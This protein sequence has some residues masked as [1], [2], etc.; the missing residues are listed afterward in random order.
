MTMAQRSDNSIARVIASHV[1]ALPDAAVL[2]SVI[3]PV[4]DERENIVPL[5]REIQLALTGVVSYEVL[6]VDDGSCDGTPEILHE[7]RRDA[8]MLRV[9]RHDISAGQST[10]IRTGVLAA[11]GR[12]IAT[13]DG[14]GQNDPADILALLVE[15]RRLSGIRGDDR[16]MIA[17][18]RTARFDSAFKRWQSRVANRVRAAVLGDGTP[19]SGCGLKVFSRA[20]FVSLPYFDHMHRFLPALVRREGGDVL[21]LP[22]RHRPRTR[23]VSHY[24]LLNRLWV[25]VVDM[26]G[27]A[28]MSRRARVPV[29]TELPT[30]TRLESV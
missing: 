29:V 20:L 1:A 18:W 2:L 30:G 3:V 4:R 17:G 25:G 26:A 14:D 11:R 13:L 10:A 9:L 7:A 8:P 5:L 27:V 24:G 6:Y 15:A 16:V 19:D 23:G 28:W 22:V 12:W 21:S